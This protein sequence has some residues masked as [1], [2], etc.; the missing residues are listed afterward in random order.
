MPTLRSA[1]VTSTL[2]NSN[3][4]R[5]SV[6]RNS[7][8]PAL[9]AG[10]GLQSTATP[11]SGHISSSRHRTTPSPMPRSCTTSAPRTSR[12]RREEARE[13]PPSFASPSTPSF[14]SR[15]PPPSSARRSARRSGC[16]SFQSSAAATHRSA[17][18]RR[19]VKSGTYS[20]ANASVF[21]RNGRYAAVEE[22]VL[23][24]LSSTSPGQD[25]AAEPG[26]AHPLPAL[27]RRFRTA[28]PS[29][30]VS[31]T[32]LAPN[33]AAARPG[34]P[35]PAPISTTSAPLTTF[36]LRASHRASATPLCHA[37][38]GMLFFA[39]PRFSR[40]CRRCRLRGARSVPTWSTVRSGRRPRPPRAGNGA[41]GGL[42]S[43][44]ICSASPAHAATAEDVES[45]TRRITRSWPLTS[46]SAATNSSSS[47]ASAVMASSAATVA[48]DASASSTRRPPTR[49][50][51]TRSRARA[52]R[53]S[54]AASSGSSDGSTPI[55]PTAADIPPAQRVPRGARCGGARAR[56]KR[57]T[58]IATFSEEVFPR[59]VTSLVYALRP[60]R[61][62]LVSVSRPGASR[63]RVGRVDTFAPGSARA[64]CGR[65]GRRE[66]RPRVAAGHRRRE[67]EN[68]LE[69]IGW[70][71]PRAGASGGGDRETREDRRDER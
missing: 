27:Y 65:H 60:R 39:P 17:M 29:R 9:C 32:A 16:S 68:R 52:T 64:L 28:A 53:T 42:R 31:T 30:S 4:E 19:R 70:E 56:L 55:R 40:A 59:Q 14:A 3:D 25:A 10:A 71:H 45:V 21:I 49:S 67:E 43:A 46:P 41:P 35:S 24:S 20:R 54:H 5:R 61:L 18:R 15:R 57:R 2:E 44:H 63:G 13:N 12:K 62:A 51:D 38:L 58:T 7:A 33:A 37:M 48:A 69:R 23:A 11:R 1:L 34:A 22:A 66:A 6:S 36:S 47:A 8:A 50:R 26:G